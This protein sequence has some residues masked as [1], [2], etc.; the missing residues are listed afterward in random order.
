[1]CI[2]SPIAS[3]SITRN[4]R[5]SPQRSTA[6]GPPLPPAARS[7]L[8]ALATCPRARTTFRAPPRSALHPSRSRRPSAPAARGL[9]PTPSPEPSSSRSPAPGLKKKKKKKKKEKKK[10]K[11]KRRRVLRRARVHRVRGASCLVLLQA[12]S[13][14]TPYCPIPFQWGTSPCRAPLPRVLRGTRILRARCR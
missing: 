4:S 9:S 2:A 1:M 6:K 14:Y 13:E 3:I 12:A 10:K 8:L 5:T 11:K 7:G